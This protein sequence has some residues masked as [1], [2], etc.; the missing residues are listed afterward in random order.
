MGH[1]L[2]SWVEVGRRVAGAR[3]SAGLTQ[4]NLAVT[5]DIERTALAKVE[6]GRRSLNSLE[7]ARIAA[8]LRRPIEWFVTESPRSVVS[9]R[10]EHLEEHDGLDPHVDAFARDIELLIELKALPPVEQRDTQVPATLDESATMAANVRRELG[11]QDGPLHNLAA[12]AERL[13][14]LVH[15]VALEQH[16][17][18]GAYV[19]LEGAAATVVNG[20]QTAGRRRFTLAHELGHHVM[21]DEYSTDWSVGEAKEEREK[22]INAFAIHLLMPR[23][24]VVDS[25]DA[26][27]GDGEPGD[28]MIRLAVEYRVSWTAACGHLQNLG[29]IDREVENDIRGHP[30]TRSDLLERGLFIVEELAPPTVSPLFV[31][32]VLRAYRGSKITA[33]RAIELLRGTLARDD[34][35]AVDI[36]PPEALRAEFT[37]SA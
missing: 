32:A 24:S 10:A 11:D 28:A 14:L 26:H 18:D 6:L 12:A 25:W 29:V 35:P 23:R 31:N 4:E 20:S 9:R 8:A 17:P 7:L 16:L 19:A 27:G 22:R 15:S 33:E 30:P 2:G 21:A 5:A 34:L 37:G 36:V 3:D 1:A 13:G